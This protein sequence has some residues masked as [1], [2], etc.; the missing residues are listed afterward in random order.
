MAIENLKAKGMSLVSTMIGLL[1]GMVCILAIMAMFKVLA[2]NSSDSGI[3]ARAEGAISTGMVAAQM[4]MQKTGFGLE[5][6]SNSCLGTS[7]KGP[8]G[9]VNTDLV[10]LSNATL[11]GATLS[12]TAAT[13]GSGTI[14]GNAVVTHW[15]DGPTDFCAAFLSANSGLSMLGPVE[16]VNASSYATATWTQSKLIPDGVVTSYPSPH[17][18]SNFFSAQKVASCA[19]YGKVAKTSGVLLSFAVGNSVAGTHTKASICLPNICK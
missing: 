6:S 2:R 11:A 18:E 16:C 14:W 17:T 1:M 9:Q 12:G 19:P 15:R 3:S 5:S 7:T 4:E 13:I 10:L 8:N